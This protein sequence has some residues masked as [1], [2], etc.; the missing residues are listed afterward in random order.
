M[1]KIYLKPLID[2]FRAFF[3]QILGF[4]ALNQRQW[5]YWNVN[6]ILFGEIMSFSTLNSFQKKKNFFIQ[7]CKFLPQNLKILS[8]QIFILMFFESDFCNWRR[9]FGFGCST[10]ET[11][12]KNPIHS[13][14][15]FQPVHFSWIFLRSV[16]DLY[17]KKII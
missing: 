10:T 6:L 2:F 17:G 16:P 7:Y 14:L 11:S 15:C 8:Y 1:E 4:L 3:G 9:S 12:P 5:L 13:G